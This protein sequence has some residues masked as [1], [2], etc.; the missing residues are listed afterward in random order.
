MLRFQTPPDKIFMA[1][2]EDSI[3][4]MIDQ[5]KAIRLS[6]E[7]KDAERCEFESLLPFAGRVFNHETALNILKRM[8]TCHKRPGLYHLN[9]YHYLI[10][11]DTLQ[12]FCEIHNDMVKEASV[13]H[14][15]KRLSKV[16]AFYIERINFDD[17]IDI[18][19]Y[20]TDFLMDADTMM[21]LGAEKRRDLGIG[22]E[23]FGISQ[24]LSPHPEELKI[25]LQ[26]N[27]KPILIIP[28]KFWSPAS[29]VYPDMD[30]S[31]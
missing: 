5:I 28:S 8:I 7:D 26:N 4:L 14:E 19:F 13:K 6:G 2:L 30:L 31:E 9:D 24:G 20:D 12:H 27:E 23:T 17:L 25:K 21:N 10:L 22:D 29:R 11:Y 3:M 18:Y 1:I 15:K 16:G